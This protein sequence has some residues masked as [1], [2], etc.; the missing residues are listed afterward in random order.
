VSGAW[1]G[2]WRK[3]GDKGE[4]L[5]AALARAEASAGAMR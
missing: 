5:L 4:M 1:R 2:E 3:N